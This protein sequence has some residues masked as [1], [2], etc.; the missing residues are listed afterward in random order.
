VGTIVLNRTTVEG[1]RL[2]RAIIVGVS[3]PEGEHGAA[4]EEQD[5]S[6]HL[7]TILS[8]DP[9]GVNAR[10]KGG[11]KVHVHVDADDYVNVYADVPSG[12]YGRPRR[13]L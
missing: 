6:R 5:S 9:E 8:A 4:Q 7:L 1:A 10:V 3:A 2:A 13:S 11:V 12:L